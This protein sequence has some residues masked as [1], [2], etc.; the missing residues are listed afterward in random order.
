MAHV[1]GIFFHWL[2]LAP[3]ILT[4]Q[5]KGELVVVCLIYL[6][7]RWIWC[8]KFR[9]QSFGAYFRALQPPLNPSETCP[10]KSENFSEKLP[11]Y[12]SFL[13]SKV[14]TVSAAFCVHVRSLAGAHS[15]FKKQKSLPLPTCTDFHNLRTQV[16]FLLV[17]TVIHNT[18]FC[19][20]VSWVYEGKCLLL[21]KQLDIQIWSQ[22][23]KSKG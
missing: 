8:V 4:L 10:W 2:V 23:H 16:Y 15:G 9:L 11:M 7:W 5:Q 14:E 1:I 20:H 6:F 18:A 17:S 12:C 21:T 13:Q 19:I 22:S 3:I